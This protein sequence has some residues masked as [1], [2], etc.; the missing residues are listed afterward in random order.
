MIDLIP[1][2][3]PA[4]IAPTMAT[5]QQV[6]QYFTRCKWYADIFPN[7]ANILYMCLSELPM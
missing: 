2:K 4:Y 1:K 5:I 7:T 3:T 6:S